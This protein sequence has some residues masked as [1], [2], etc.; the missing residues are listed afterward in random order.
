VDVDF[1][2][3][4]G[5][6][7]SHF[8]WSHYITRLAT[9]S[10]IYD[11]LMVTCVAVDDEEEEYSSELSSLISDLGERI[12]RAAEGLERAIYPF[13]EGWKDDALDV[14]MG[15]QITLREMLERVEW[16]T[17]EKWVDLSEAEIEADP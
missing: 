2:S 12:N 17:E 11:I 3:T 13:R 14:I 1:A 7:L 15:L 6:F 9:L 16:L 10:T 5:F 4:S 8:K